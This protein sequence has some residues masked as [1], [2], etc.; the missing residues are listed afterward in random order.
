M[1]NIHFL[2]DHGAVMYNANDGVVYTR[3]G[4]SSSGVIESFV[5]GSVGD[6]TGFTYTKYPDPQGRLSYS[7]E[8]MAVG[9]NLY[10]VER[11]DITN[12]YSTVW[13]SAPVSGVIRWC[14]SF[15]MN[16]RLNSSDV[17]TNTDYQDAIIR[18]AGRVASCNVTAG[19]L[20]EV[21]TNDAGPRNFKAII[22]P[23][24]YP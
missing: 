22:I 16:I 9:E 2:T 15:I 5:A 8:E 23:F 6:I 7:A 3:V 17:Y 20:V 13:A 1:A 10:Y 21:S 19:D 11:S 14:G 4:A 24:V 12:S 18:D